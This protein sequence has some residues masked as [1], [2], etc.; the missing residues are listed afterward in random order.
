M[1][2]IVS[3]IKSRMQRALEVLRQDFATVRTGRA[4]SSLVENIVINCY[5]GTQ[6]LK[7]LELATIHVQDNRTIAINPFDKSIVGDIERGIAN[8]NVGL[9]PIVDGDILR[10]NLPPLTEERRLE[11]I[12]LIKQKAESGK[13]ML[14]QIR[15]EGME[16]VKKRAESES[17]SEDEVI[18][19]EKEIQKVTD[20]FSARL[21]QLL[22]GKEKELMTI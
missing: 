1:E 16:D 17:I 14:R 19:I 11:L 2:S 12:K 15:H 9:N 22:E 3:E 8:A 13:V 6:Q 7:V 5:G 21:D 18:R 4:S 20:D 10:I